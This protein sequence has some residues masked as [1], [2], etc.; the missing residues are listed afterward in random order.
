VGKSCCIDRSVAGAS[1]LFLA[2]KDEKNTVLINIPD[3]TCL[4]VEQYARVFSE[5]LFVTGNISI[6]LG[7]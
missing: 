3:W 1:V 6:L 7:A 4:L 2:G 5:T